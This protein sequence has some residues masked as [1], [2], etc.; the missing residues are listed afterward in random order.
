MI[1]R[2]VLHIH[3]KAYTKGELNNCKGET[4]H[5]PPLNKGRLGGDALV[6]R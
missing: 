3:S 4:Q 1:T 5:I 6:S 2:G